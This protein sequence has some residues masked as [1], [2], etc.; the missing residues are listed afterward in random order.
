MKQKKD[1]RPDLL[2][3]KTETSIKVP[4]AWLRDCINKEMVGIVM[5]HEKRIKNIERR[6][7]LLEQ[8][9]YV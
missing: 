7:M 1:T 2:N 8:G 9:G 5:R 4:K 6:I 3:Y